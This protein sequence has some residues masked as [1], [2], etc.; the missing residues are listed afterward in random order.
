MFLQYLTLHKNWNATLTSWSRGLLTL[1]TV[2][3]RA[4]STKPLISGKHSSCMC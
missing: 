4:S 1:G 3:F 2:L